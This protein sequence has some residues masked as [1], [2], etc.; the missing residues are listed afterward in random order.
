MQHVIVNTIGLIALRVLIIRTDQSDPSCPQTDSEP[1][2]RTSSRLRTD[3][4]KRQEN[5]F[6][7]FELKIQLYFNYFYPKI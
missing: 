5:R 3:R 2:A 4:L 1:S 7:C 6:V